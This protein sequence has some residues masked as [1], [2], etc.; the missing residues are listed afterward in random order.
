MTN[1]SD[2]RILHGRMYVENV[3]VQQVSGYPENRKASQAMDRY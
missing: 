3:T 2:K 1:I